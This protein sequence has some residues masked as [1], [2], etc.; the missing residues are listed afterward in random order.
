MSKIKTKN[1]LSVYLL[2]INI[3]MIYFTL[4]IY[5]NHA[6]NNNPKYEKNKTNTKTNKI[7]MSV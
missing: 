1:R 2:Q 4:E 5:L 6:P 7:K 3:K